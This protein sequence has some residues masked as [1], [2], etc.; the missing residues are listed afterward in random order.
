MSLYEDFDKLQE[1]GNSHIAIIHI[2]GNGIGKIFQKCSSLSEVRKNSCVLELVFNK[3]FDALLE[4]IKLNLENILDS[5]GAKNKNILPIRSL[6][7]GGDDITFI[8]P[9]KLSFYFT[10]IFLEELLK[11]A[12]T[13]LKSII[14]DPFS[15]CAGIA[16]TKI[17]YPFY[18]GYKL[19]EDACQLAKDE[20]KEK[21]DNGSWIDFHIQYGSL[22]GELKQIRE[23]YKVPS[24]NL[25]A[26]PYKFTAQ[27]NSYEYTY[28]DLKQ[29]SFLLSNF[30][31]NKIHRFRDVLYK[32]KSYLDSFKREM[33]GKEE[34][35]NLFNFKGISEIFNSDNSD[36]AT[37]Y[38][39]D[40]IEFIEFY[41]KF[42]YE[43]GKKHNH[44]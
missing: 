32:N 24:G 6:V 21:K 11:N 25:L 10:E 36:E 34:N 18:K 30:A 43:K 16:I 27:E 2:D 41:P 15:I 20:R 1:D 33:E 38:F 12:A 26:R 44:E 4:K 13:E 23:Q 31:S 17:G 5:I 22:V 28:N 39:F 14:E 3:S 19:A 35:W 37:T 29:N 40:M 9:G 7:I 8:C 42:L